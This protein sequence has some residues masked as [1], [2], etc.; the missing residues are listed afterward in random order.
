M[1]KFCLALVAASVSGIAVLGQ[2][3]QVVKRARPEWAFVVPDKDQPANSEGSGPQHI[4]GSD[5]AYTF[6]QIEDLGHPP[7]WFPNDHGPVPAVVSGEGIK[8]RGR[9]VI[10]SFDVG[11]G[12]SG[13]G[14]P[15]GYASRVPGTADGRLQIRGTQQPR[16][17]WNCKID[18]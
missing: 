11:R 10:V 18:F 17:E 12:S 7:D 2:A 8:V 6:A 13:V 5:R 3:V 14:G 9:C 4:P 1:T 15:R 16:D